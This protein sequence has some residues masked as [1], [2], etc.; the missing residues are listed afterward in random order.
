[1]ACIHNTRSLLSIQVF[2]RDGFE[3]SGKAYKEDAYG[4]EPK[5]AS[6]PK[7]SR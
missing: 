7:E 5:K 2:L 3:S 1:M 4:G 6:S